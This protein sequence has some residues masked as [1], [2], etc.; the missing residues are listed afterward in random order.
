MTLKISEVSRDARLYWGQF[1]SFVFFTYSDKTSNYVSVKLHRGQLPPVS[2]R[3]GAALK[4]DAR[5]ES[6][7]SSRIS[8]PGGLS[9]PRPP[10]VQDF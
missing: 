2:Y 6:A 5:D 3:G 10:Q 7:A 1:D 8:R 4:M 9:P